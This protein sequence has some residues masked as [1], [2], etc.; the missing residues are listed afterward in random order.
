MKLTKAELIKIIKEE[1]EAVMEQ[2]PQAMMVRGAKGAG[3]DPF[4]VEKIRINPDGTFKARLKSAQL[5]KPLRVAGDLDHNSLV[6]LRQAGALEGDGRPPR[7]KPQHPAHAAMM[8][9]VDAIKANYEGVEEGLPPAIAEL[10]DAVNA[11]DFEKLRDELTNIW[12]ALLKW[13][14]STG[15]RLQHSTT[16]TFNKIN[17]VVRNLD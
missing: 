3:R 7:G 16:T 11:G 8:E 13:H 10:E 2:D 5:E 17:T 12:N 14:Q 15:A 9:G 6:L 4:S 1:Y